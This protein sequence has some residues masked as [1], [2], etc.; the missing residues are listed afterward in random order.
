MTSSKANAMRHFLT[1]RALA[2]LLIIASTLVLSSCASELTRTGAS[3]SFIIIDM[4]QGSPGHSPDEWVNPL[5]SDVQTYVE[6][7]ID[8]ERVRFATY[9]ND[10]GLA[11]MRLGMKNPLNP[12]GPST[13]NTITIHRYRVSF[14]RSDGRNTPGVDVPHAFDGALTFTIPQDGTAGV[15]FDV[16][17]NQAKLEAPLINMRGGGGARFI[18]TLAEVTFY[19][20]DQV[21][22]EVTATGTLAVNFGDFAD[23]E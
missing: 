4:I 2:G 14:R 3:P 23:P 11:T 12:T 8:G 21:G 19:G 5:F 20:R 7:Q 18:T 16:V 1:S 9:F 17:R 22:N 10:L 6:R 13:V 15:P